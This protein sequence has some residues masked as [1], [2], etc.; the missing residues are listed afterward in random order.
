MEERKKMMKNKISMITVTLMTAFTLTACGGAGSD[1]MPVADDGK[2]SGMP[3]I[4]TGT[5]IDL[6]ALNA[7][8]DNIKNLDLSGADSAQEDKTLY[9]HCCW[10]SWIPAWEPEEP[11]QHCKNKPSTTFLSCTAHVTLSPARGSSLH[12]QKHNDQHSL[13]F[14]DVCCQKG[15][16]TKLREN[17]SWWEETF[18]IS[19][20][21]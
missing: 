7:S 9:G 17:G 10:S 11:C 15:P 4:D 12:T 16:S 5:D 13:T 6:D 18:R 20:L 14:T 2:L 8:V 3:E 19:E 21:L 1:P